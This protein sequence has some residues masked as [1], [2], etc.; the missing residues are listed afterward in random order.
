MKKIVLLITIAAFFVSCEKFLDVTPKDKA[1]QKDLLNDISGFQMGL[2]AVYNSMNTTS[3]YGRDLKFGF[4]ETLVGTYNAPNSAHSYYR[5][6]R[7]EYSLILSPINGIWTS[8]YGVINQVNIMLQDVDK[9]PNSLNKDLIIGELYGIRAFCHFELLK[10]FGPVIKEQGL[11]VSSIPYRDALIFTSSKFN[12]AAEVIS[13]L[14]KDLT[15]ARL[16]FQE[17]PIRTSSRVSNGNSLTY[18][19]Y[20]SL[21]DRRGNRMNY[22][23]VVALQAQVSQWEGNLQKAAE[24]AEEVIT[25]VSSNNVIRFTTVAE[26]SSTYN[27][28]MPNENIFALI[29][30]SFRTNALSIFS[31]IGDTRATSTSPLLF[32]NYTWLGTNLYNNSAHGSVSDFRYKAGNWF[33]SDPAISVTP[34]KVVKYHFAESE[35]VSNINSVVLFETKLISLHDIYMIAAEYYASSNPVKAI[36]YLNTVRSARDIITPFTYNTSMDEVTIKNFIFDELRK[37]N[38]GEGKL[39]TEYKRLFRAID[40]ATAVQPTL[41]RFTFPIPINEQTYNPQ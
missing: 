35:S 7:H 9:L 8:L 23:A 41:A 12:T 16:A 38:I 15:A 26:L 2:A 33:Q 36:T 31:A 11:D 17:D 6:F 27:K 39:F 29:N 30:Q 19:K 14:N 3:L 37:E 1:Y 10:L 28:R 13:K 18:E 22:Y 4:M 24:F 5:A 40:R 32:P 20:N 25:E 34:F 21:V